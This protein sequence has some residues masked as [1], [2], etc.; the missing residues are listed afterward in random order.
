MKKLLLILALFS[1]VQGHSQLEKGASLAGVQLNLAAH[2]MYGARLSFRTGFMEKSFGISIAPTF[3]WALQHNWLLGSFATLGIE[4]ATNKGLGYSDQNILYTDLGLAAFTRYYVDI[5]KNQ[6]WKLFGLAALEM[7]TA[8]SKISYDDNFGT[9]MHRS[10][11]TIMG[12][13][14]G[15]VSYF[16]KELAFDLSMSTT[17]LRFG[18]YK[19]F[20]AGKK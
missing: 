10:N 11:T 16:A 5:S 15:G 13:L 9:T 18:I 6:K 14:G 8:R 4:N 17:A 2:D 3:S 19:M 12:A 1:M 7:N 20:P